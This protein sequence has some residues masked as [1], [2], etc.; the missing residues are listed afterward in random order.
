MPR[1]PKYRG[2]DDLLESLI[3]GMRDITNAEADIDEYVKTIDELNQRISD[4]EHYIENPNNII[5]RS[6]A[7]RFVQELRDLRQRRRQVKQMWELWKVYGNNRE[8][9][10]QKD[11]REMLI[12]ELIKTDKNLQTE[13]NYRIYDVKELDDMNKVRRLPREVKSYNNIEEEEVNEESREE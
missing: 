13:Y 2:K 3:K 10:K 12:A 8:K 7:I 5:T 9:V 1:K 6:G 11:Y 4:I